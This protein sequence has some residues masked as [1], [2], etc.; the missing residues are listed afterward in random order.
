MKLVGITPARAGKTRRFLPAMNKTR[1]HPRS[2]GKDEYC[3]TGMLSSGWITPAR[4][5]KTCIFDAQG[6]RV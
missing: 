1:D 6:D 2:C 5:G 3:Q 4:A